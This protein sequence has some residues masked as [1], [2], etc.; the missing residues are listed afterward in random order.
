MDAYDGIESCNN[1]KYSP[2]E[3]LDKF[4][5]IIVYGDQNIG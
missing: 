2:F 4:W 3:N 1:L 5:L